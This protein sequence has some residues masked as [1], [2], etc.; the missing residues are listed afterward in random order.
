MRIYQAFTGLA[1]FAALLGSS[2]AVVAQ[3]ATPASGTVTAGVTRQPLT[4]EAV[5]HMDGMAGPL[6][7]ERLRIPAGA[8]ITM[9]PEDGELVVIVVEGGTLQGS[10]PAQVTIQ[11]QDQRGEATAQD[12][13]AGDLI[14]LS[15]GDVL[16]SLA[17]VGM[18]LSATSTEQA[19]V[20]RIGIGSD[21]PLA[22]SATAEE[23]VPSGL[24]MALS[25]VIPPACPPGTA[26][27]APRDAATPLAGG[28]GG[29]S[30]AFAVALAAAPACVSQGTPT[31]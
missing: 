12:I 26:P 5:S 31:P 28:G 14:N 7:I 23:G 25:L 6:T 11:H 15:S 29:G 13:A 4:S 27:E 24:V 10:S 22:E 19:M 1:L 18:E 21:R 9:T 8:G 2:V 17:P 3:D 30:G 20:V 16:V